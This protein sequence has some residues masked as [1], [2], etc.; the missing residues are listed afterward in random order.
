MPASHG[1]TEEA[2]R[3]YPADKAE[4]D[5]DRRIRDFRERSTMIA[6]AFSNDPAGYYV[7]YSRHCEANLDLEGHVS[8]IADYVDEHGLSEEDQEHER[9]MACMERLHGGQG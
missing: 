9:R 2:A 3:S 4:R 6:A 1:W 5:L 8:E 7:A